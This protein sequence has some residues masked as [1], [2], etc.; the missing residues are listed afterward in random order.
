MSEIDDAQDGQ[1]VLWI[2]DG[3]RSNN[4]GHANVYTILIVQGNRAVLCGCNRMA[5]WLQIVVVQIE[6]QKHI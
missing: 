5:Q 4:P 1:D 3:M 6:M 2:E